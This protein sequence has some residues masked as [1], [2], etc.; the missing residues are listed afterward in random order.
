MQVA[1]WNSELEPERIAANL[2]L[3][4]HVVVP[5]KYQATMLA[6]GQRD[7]RAKIKGAAF[8][9]VGRSAVNIDLRN[10]DAFQVVIGN[11]LVVVTDH[12]DAHSVGQF[13]AG[14]ELGEE[15]VAAVVVRIMIGP[16]DDVVKA[17][18][19]LFL[20]VTRGQGD[21]GRGSK[22]DIVLADVDGRA[23]DIAGARGLKLQLVVPVRDALVA[24]DGNRNDVDVTE[25]IIREL[26]VWQVELVVFVRD[27]DPAIELAAEELDA[28]VV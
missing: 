11:L 2:V 13:L 14:I 9:A 7:L 12:A 21:G 19:D 10:E 4:Q 3:H 22:R 24:Q 18:A 27:G 1:E 23:R 16:V 26:A 5:L 28:P 15:L 17:G 8:V 20:A 25:G 6:P